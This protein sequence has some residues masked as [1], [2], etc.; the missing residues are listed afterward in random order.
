VIGRTP[1]RSGSS[2]WPQDKPAADVEPFDRAREAR[3][4]L[5]ETVADA[6]EKRIL[7]GQLRPADLLP[8][9][10]VLSEQ[11]KVS[12]TVVR[13]AIK[14]L[15]HSGLVEARQGLGV[16]VATSSGGHVAESIL[17]FVKLE[18]SP[19]WSLYE[20]RSIL[21][22]EAAALAAIRRDDNDLGLLQSIIEG[23]TEKVDA[24]LEY[25]ELDLEF[26]RALLK[27]A[28]NPIFNLVLEPFREALRES[29]VLGATVPQAPHRSLSSHQRICEA[30]R[31][32]DAERARTE[33]KGHFDKVAEFLSEAGVPT[34]V[35]GSD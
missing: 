28:H 10:R 12:R 30:I 18:N 24:P 19:Q 34:D 26:H 4:R 9:E 2:A 35:P 23:M 33:V 3:G 1:A 22:T 21:E 31:S 6:I 15:E 25:V 32:Q 20:F 13:E 16:V 29:R 5:Y 11:F 17:R 7:S 14:A 27:A 8:P